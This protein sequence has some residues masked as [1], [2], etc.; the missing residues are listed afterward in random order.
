MPSFTVAGAL[1]QLSEGGKD[2]WNWP[3]WQAITG[4]SSAP[5]VVETETTP[6]PLGWDAQ[7]LDAVQAFVRAFDTRTKQEDRVRFMRKRDDTYSVG[8]E[9]WRTF[10]TTHW[11]K[12]WRLE[13]KVM[14]ILQDNALAP[15]DQVKRFDA[16]ALP[17]M[18]DC[19][20][21]SAHAGI[22]FALFGLNG[23]QEPVSVQFV[24]PKVRHFIPFDDSSNVPTAGQIRTYIRKLTTAIRLLKQYGDTASIEQFQD[25]KRQ[26]QDILAAQG[27]TKD[28]NKERIPKVLRDALAKL[29]TEQQA[30][31]LQAEIAKFLEDLDDED[32]DD[33]VE[34]E[35]NNINLAQAVEDWKEGVEQYK[36]YSMDDLWNMLG[37]RDVKRIPDFQEK[38]DTDGSCQPW[39]ENG[40]QWLSTSPEAVPLRINWHQLVGIVHMVD[41]AL[42]GLPV[43]L[44]DEVGVGKTMQAVGLIGTLSFFREFYARHGHFPGKWKDFKCSRTDDCDTGNIPDRPILLGCPAN[45]HGQLSQELER[46][47]K[48]RSFDV[49]P[50]VGKVEKRMDFWTTHFKASK[51]V[52]GRKIVLA[53]HTALASDALA[54]WRMESIDGA[55]PKK[56]TAAESLQGSTVFGRMWSLTIIDEAHFARKLGRLYVAA[57][58][59]R[60]ASF[61][62]VAMTAT[63]ILTDPI[64]RMDEGHDVH[65]LRGALLGKEISGNNSHL[66]YPGVV[67]D[68]I[69][70]IRDKFKGTVIRRSLTST[71]NEGKPISGLEPY[72]EHILLLKLHDWERENLYAIAGELAESTSGIYATATVTSPEVT[73]KLDILAKIVTWHL[74]HDGR[75]PLTSTDDG[76]DVKENKDEAECS[77]RPT[78]PDKIVVFSLFPSSNQILIDILSLCGIKVVEIHGKMPLQRRRENLFKFKSAA[79]NGP[80]VLILSGVGMDTLWSA[81]E[82]AQLIG[83]IWRQPQ[84]KQVHVYRLIA[85]GTPDVF[86]NNISFDKSIMHQAFVGTGEHLSKDSIAHSLTTR[87]QLTT[88][89]AF[90]G[91]SADNVPDTPASD[92]EDPICNK[93]SAKGKGREQP[94]PTRP[95]KK[96]KLEESVSGPSGRDGEGRPAKKR[97]AAVEE[98]K[99]TNRVEIDQPQPR[100]KPKPWLRQTKD[101]SK[102]EISLRPF[103]FT[104]TFSDRRFGHTDPSPPTPTHREMTTQNGCR[105][106]GSQFVENTQGAA[107]ESLEN[108]DS[109][110]NVLELDEI[111]DMGKLLSFEDDVNRSGGD[112]GT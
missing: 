53:A 44:M 42:S 63:P 96:R 5:W 19:G 56:R 11:L 62:T 13:R 31:R 18:E 32:A 26:L 41:R 108:L 77:G 65:I 43:L 70:T 98:A 36:R 21:E 94:S 17:P 71:D 4:L 83:R 102:K 68:A 24:L 76:W 99:D 78:A 29:A 45:L 69:A 54:V 30:R 61:S 49:I 82:D 58:A 23:Y 92:D 88:G 7:T 84:P 55:S 74:E 104:P 6:H 34:F 22:A 39:T 48:W 100:S 91:P 111:L 109:T 9:A 93:P 8:R 95:G 40:A 72:R 75:R 51:H 73:V 66:E 46:Y 103:G 86:L 60:E 87:P 90:M 81:Q 3:Q 80:R 12:E 105:A 37:L 25:R 52:P 110:V 79:R 59:L 67:Q 101:P 10:V 14:D 15:I 47:L 107:T 85:R 50:Y 106:G 38:I 28:G 35:E 27:A 33:T 64:A 97:G 1:L 112:D 2:P 20:L 57:R 89:Q 16:Q